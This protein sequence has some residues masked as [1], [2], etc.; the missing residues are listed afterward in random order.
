MKTIVKMNLRMRESIQSIQLNQSNSEP[1][2]TNWI[3]FALAA[4]AAV[5]LILS[6]APVAQAQVEAL[7]LTSADQYRDVTGLTDA[8]RA[9]I[10]TLAVQQAMIWGDT[11]LEGDFEAAGD[12]HIDRIQSVYEGEHFLGYRVSYSETA[13][14]TSNCTYNPR[15]KSTLSSCLSGRI[16]ESMFVTPDLKDAQRDERDFAHFVN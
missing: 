14:A 3:S 15:D 1:V 6:H 11:I 7:N 16:S 13:W 8:Q 5:V 9:Q 2:L 12:T 4:F 10:Q